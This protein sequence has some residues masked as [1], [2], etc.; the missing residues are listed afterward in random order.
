MLQGVQFAVELGHLHL[1]FG[2][3][4]LPFY[5]HPSEQPIATQ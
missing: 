2:D 4:S 5:P 1:K 3:R